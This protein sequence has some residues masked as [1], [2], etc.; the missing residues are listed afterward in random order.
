MYDRGT[1]RDQLQSA[2]EH[3]LSGR[4]SS[5][6]SNYG[7]RYTLD[8]NRGQ[9]GYGPI[10]RPTPGTFVQHPTIEEEPEE[11]MELP[12]SSKAGAARGNMDKYFQ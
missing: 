5:R 10:E 1:P 7:L 6:R 11:E 9:L 2:A 12:E 8:R 3:T 4:G